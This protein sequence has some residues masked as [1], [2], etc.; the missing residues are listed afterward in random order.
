[1]LKKG[2]MILVIVLIVAVFA[3]FAG[4]RL[5]RNTGSTT[6]IA[7]IT[8]NGK[9][10]RKI[11]LD[12]VQGSERIQISGEY[13]EVILAEKGRIRFESANCPDRVCVKTG[14]LSQKGDAAVC[15]PNRTII[16]IEGEK[17]NVD[18]VAY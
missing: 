10:V 9:V 1:M 14:W 11:N 16:K 3:S 7:V 2:D 8:Q 13:D 5:F 17:E 15:L 6:K 4:L 18:G 12:K